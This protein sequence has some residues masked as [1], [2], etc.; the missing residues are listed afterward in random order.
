MIHVKQGDAWAEG[1][2]PSAITSFKSH[3]MPMILAQCIRLAFDKAE[4]TREDI[5][6]EPLLITTYRDG[7]R[8]LTVTA[9]AVGLDR[10]LCDG[11]KQWPYKAKNWE[12]IEY[13]DAPDLSLKEK[14]RID[15]YLNRSSKY[16]LERL[17]FQLAATEE[18]SLKVIDSYKKYHRFYPEFRS[19]DR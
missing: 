7:Q 1:C 8:M 13:I 10:E 3:E 17:K 2:P 18:K 9:K 16:I 19:I 14:H 5:R 15:M 11:I 6:F 12:S 4:S